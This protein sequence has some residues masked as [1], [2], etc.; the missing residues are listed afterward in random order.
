MNAA[1]ALVAL[2]LATLA[3][4]VV[5]LATW[6]RGRPGER[7]D[8]AVSVLVPARNEATRI[9][10]CLTAIAASEHP[11]AEILVYDD[12]STDDTRAIVAT[13]AARDPRIRLVA[14]VPL[15]D[16][17]IGK[18]HGC[19]RLARAS[20]GDVLVF[21][22]ADVRLAPAGL[23]RLASIFADGACSVVTA[24]PRQEMGSFVERLLL[25][26]LLVTYLSWLPLELVARTDDP[27]VVAANGQI[28]GLRRAALER[29]GYFHCVAR[30]VVDDVALC[31]A[32]KRA[33]LRV[34]FVDGAAM[35]TCRMYASGSALWEGF[36]K[37]IA[38]GVGGAGG[39]AVAIALYLAAF[40]APWI[41]LLAAMPSALRGDQP[42]AALPAV[43]AVSANLVQRGLIALRYRQP[44]SSVVWHP[45]AIGALIVLALRSLGWSLRGRVRWSGRV[46]A[47]RS[48]RAAPSE[49]G[50]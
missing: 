42:T 8:G 27:R 5:N 33:G 4:T 26:L 1:W 22:D 11:I 43:V 14:T 2:P 39:V 13:H 19:E 25:P 6:R 34:A 18:A 44:A 46:Y 29:L 9:G 30:E 32:A 40:L 10:D 50:T 48:E 28:V 7:F 12:E 35:A 37:N 38:E 17:W 16:G 20:R 41:A 21:L 47:A 49:V 24:V 31:R 15:P 36:S 45:L 23:G 3:M